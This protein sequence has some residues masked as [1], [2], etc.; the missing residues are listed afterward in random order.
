M[1]V[2][3]EAATGPGRRAQRITD[4]TFKESLTM[5][6]ILRHKGVLSSNMKML[7]S[8]ACPLAG[9]YRIVRQHQVSTLTTCE[10]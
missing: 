2:Q 1:A 8:W 4:M 5:V 7:W 6:I 3:A 10:L 9:R